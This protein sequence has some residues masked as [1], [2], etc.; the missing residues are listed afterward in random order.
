MALKTRAKRYLLQALATGATAGL[1]K[2]LFGRGTVFCLHQVEAADDEIIATDVAIS[3]KALDCFLSSL[4]ELGCR[5]VSI[6]TLLEEVAKDPS[7]DRLCAISF[8]DGYR[9]T[10]TTALPILRRYSAPAT[11]F[12]TTG[13]LDRTAP[14]W[15]LIGEDY[16]RTSDSVDLESENGVIQRFDTRTLKGKRHAYRHLN[17]WLYRRSIEGH[18]PNWSPLLDAVSDWKQTMDRHLLSWAE[19]R[20]AAAELD[21]EIGA[22]GA[23][24]R[25]LSVLDDEAAATEIVHVRNV[26]STQLD[27]P[28]RYMAFPFGSPQA[29]GER[30][31]KI[32]K[33][34]GFDAAF[35]T[36]HVNVLP[37]N[38]SNVHALGRKSVFSDMGSPAT[39]A[40]GSV[41]S[42]SSSWRELI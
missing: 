1:H 29:C 21:V 30:E 38:L 26:L 37:T 8:D 25:P 41:Y 15:W 24:H 33:T 11:I 16:I 35:T 42:W 18:D 9:D 5:F 10:V 4:K 3:A 7:G 27:V 13:Y 39:I 2:Q 32:C 20:T 22:H 12:L 40:E 17:R 14:H 6:A 19:A 31:W 34:A 23:T 36:K 28:V